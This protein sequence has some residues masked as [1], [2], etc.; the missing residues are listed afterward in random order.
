M[1]IRGIGSFSDNPAERYLAMLQLI[2]CDWWE[3]QLEHGGA[4]WHQSGSIEW[5][6]MVIFPDTLVI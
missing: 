1:K 4:L 5:G 6:M 3:S 2:D